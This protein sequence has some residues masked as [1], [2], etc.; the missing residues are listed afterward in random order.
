MGS[1]RGPPIIMYADAM[2]QPLRGDPGCGAL[3]ATPSGCIQHFITACPIQALDWQVGSEVCIAQAECWTQ[4]TAVSTWVDLLANNDAWFFC[5]NSSALGALIKG[6]SSAGDLNN[7]VGSIWHTLAIA[8]CWAWWEF[9]P[10]ALNVADHLSRGREDLAHELGSRR[11]EAK[12]MNV[13]A[14]RASEPFA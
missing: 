3:I 4:G 7:M 1:N 11:I 14:W 12:H 9:V 6:S 5:D 8:R 13:K 10:S 2:L